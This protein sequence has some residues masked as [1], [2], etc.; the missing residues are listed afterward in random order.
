MIALQDVDGTFRRW[1]SSHLIAQP[2]P[3]GSLSD[4]LTTSLER[5]VD[6]LL[7]VMQDM[8]AQL[9]CS[10]PIRQPSGEWISTTELANLCDCSQQ[11]IQKWIRC[12]R[13]PHDVVRKKQRGKQ[14]RY[15][16]SSEKALP[17]AMH[18]LVG[19]DT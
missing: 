10:P 2:R 5:K 11:L 3:R 18:F 16:L 15:L 13:F 14:W 17:I 8:R 1:R 9:K 7:G 19:E 4:H 6:L 12:E